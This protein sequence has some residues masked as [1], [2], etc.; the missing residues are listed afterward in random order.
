M[1]PPEAAGSAAQVQHHLHTAA[2]LAGASIPL[3]NPAAASASPKKRYCSACGT[4]AA[5]GARFCSNCAAP[6]T[7]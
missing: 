4:E 2:A 3:A 5:P 6:L 1:A 7:A